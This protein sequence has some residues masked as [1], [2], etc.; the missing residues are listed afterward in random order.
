MNYTEMKMKAE[1]QDGFTIEQW[2]YGEYKAQIRITR[3]LLKQ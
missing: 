3:M 2:L 1:E